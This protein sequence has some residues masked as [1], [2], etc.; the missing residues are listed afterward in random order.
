MTVLIAQ[1][2]ACPTVTSVAAVAEGGG[3]KISWVNPTNTNFYGIDLYVATTSTKPVSPTYTNIAGSSFSFNNGSPSQLYYFWVQTK[4]IYLQ[5]VT[6]AVQVSATF[7]S[8]SITLLP[9]TATKHTV[10]EDLVA[11]TLS[12]VAMGNVSNTVLIDYLYRSVGTRTEFNVVINRESFVTGSVKP[13]SEPI[14]PGTVKIAATC[15]VSEVTPH[16]NSSVGTITLTNGST[17]VIGSGT[18]FVAGMVG[19]LLATGET[20]QYTIATVTNTTTLTLTTPY[21]GTT[22]TIP[23]LN[24]YVIQSEINID[25]Q[26]VDLMTVEAVGYGDNCRLANATVSDL[27]ITRFVNTTVGKI[28]EVSLQVIYIG[29]VGQPPACIYKIR[30]KKLTVKEYIL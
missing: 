7:P 23:A 9:G 2:L 3:I 19:L 26:T 30:T 29:I 8:S 16:V 13:I 15:Y 11:T 4:N 21:T 10:I 1:P 28:Y 22:A 6:T 18:N 17:S 25:N 14:F 12:T 27:A 5:Q 20:S 24:W